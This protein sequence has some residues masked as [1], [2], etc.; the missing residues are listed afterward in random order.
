MIFNLFKKKC[1][2]EN[3]PIDMEFGY[4]PDC[5]KLIENEWYITRCSCCGVKLKSVIKRGDIMPELHF[6]HNC[7]SQEFLVEKLPK[8]NFVDIHFAV[9][10][11]TPKA[12]RIL[13]SYTQT[14][15]ET[16]TPNYTP[17]LLQ[18]FQ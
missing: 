18:Q 2:H 9:L 3:L 6:C 12:K 7:G 5:G 11:K 1:S 15:C 4:C 14:W 17:K 13:N 16:K 10:I 8:I